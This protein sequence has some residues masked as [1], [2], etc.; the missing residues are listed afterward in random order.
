MNIV[1]QIRLLACSGLFNYFQNISVNTIVT[2]NKFVF[3]KFGEADRSG[4]DV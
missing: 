1:T 4:R 3:E 2:G